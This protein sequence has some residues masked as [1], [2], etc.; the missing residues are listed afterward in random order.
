MEQ[1]IQQRLGKDAVRGISG[2]AM[3]Q[4][5]HE[6]VASALIAAQ[7]SQVTMDMI[8]KQLTE[9][10]RGFKGLESSVT[11]TYLLKEIEQMEDRMQ[12]LSANPD[13]F[14]PVNL[15]QPR[16]D[17][18]KRA[19][20]LKEDIRAK[21]GSISQADVD[22]RNRQEIQPD[23][24]MTTPKK[25]ILVVDDTPYNLLGMEETLTSRGEYE[26]TISFNAKHALGILKQNPDSFDLVMSDRQMPGM[27][28]DKLAEEIFQLKPTLKVV[29]VTS[30]SVKL[31]QLRVQGANNIV[32]VLGKPYTS[33]ELLA[34]A[35]E[36]LPDSAQSAT[37]DAVM[38]IL[39]N[40]DANWQED[41]FWQKFIEA[42]RIQYWNI[43]TPNEDVLGDESNRTLLRDYIQQH[44]AGFRFLTRK[45]TG[46]AFFLFLGIP[47]TRKAAQSFLRQIDLGSVLAGK[48]LL[49]SESHE[50]SL[51]W[52]YLPAVYG[53]LVSSGKGIFPSSLNDEQ[54]GK[55][56]VYWMNN[57]EQT[58]HKFDSA[59]E[60]NPDWRQWRHANP[61][62][63]TP[64]VVDGIV[65]WM[66]ETQSQWDPAMTNSS[67]VASTR[68]GIDLDRS[69][70]QMNVRKDG[71][72]VEVKFDSAMIERIKREGF[73]GLE[74]T[75]Q[76]IMPVSNLP[77]LL[78]LRKEEERLAQ[79]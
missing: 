68:G 36:F 79:I 42:K 61:E 58:W 2:A 48:H 22:E 56:L 15:T 34:K 32:A 45:R 6:V 26:V 21:L 30:D 14:S 24:A 41:S 57:F 7:G 13:F 33:Q 54:A 50:V 78:G 77:M 76:S 70:M 73:D 1:A 4:R 49:T 74:F 63:I 28:G 44:P 72:G 35:K 37:P 16:D 51:F 17:L 75:I 71:Q 66:H 59:S 31:D 47:R 46:Q 67:P 23:K 3:N 55:A 38:N 64:K 19:E 40:S 18:F 5:V 29:I 52:H 43:Q 69:K 10:R 12:G 20:R 8:S 39:Q 53:A 60:Y 27:S 65:Q 62:D 25:K 9:I 11:L